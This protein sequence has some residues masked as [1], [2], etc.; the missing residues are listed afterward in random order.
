MPFGIHRLPAGMLASASAPIAASSPLHSAI[1]C[2]V[3][4]WLC[5]RR[6]SGITSSARSGSMTVNRGRMVAKYGALNANARENT[7]SP[8]GSF[9]AVFQRVRTYGTDLAG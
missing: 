8:S 2:T 7:R 6:R 4:R 5:T 3:P 9:R 1:A